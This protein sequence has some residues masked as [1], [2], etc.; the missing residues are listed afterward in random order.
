M[1]TNAGKWTILAIILGL[2]LSLGATFTGSGRAD[3]AQEPPLQATTSQLQNIEDL[4]AA[5][6]A[7]AKTV[8]PSVVSIRVKT[9]PSH[10]T[11]PGRRPRL[12]PSPSSPH[13]GG[14]DQEEF[15][16]KLREFF[17]RDFDFID[18]RMAPRK[19]PPR[20][21]SSIQGSG[22]IIDAQKG[23]ILTNYHVVEGSQFH[24]IGLFDGSDTFGKVYAKVSEPSKSPISWN[25][26]PSTT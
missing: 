19:A 7:V 10:S 20:L 5:F 22:I 1:W 16:R 2:G 8:K 4:S 24:E 25:C 14:P 13:P 6:R 3:A 26:D 15:R 12:H 11:S 21:P 23:Y 18:P 17:G 9:Y